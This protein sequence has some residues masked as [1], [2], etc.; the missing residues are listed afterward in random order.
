MDAKDREESGDEAALENELR[1]AMGPT[2]S[3]RPEFRASVRE[4]FFRTQL[5]EKS[6]SESSSLESA[7][8]RSASDSMLED[9][10]NNLPPMPD[11]DSEFRAELKAAFL[12]GKLEGAAT[13]EGA[14]REEFSRGTK[15]GPV[16]SPKSSRGSARNA[17]ARGGE[18]PLASG[19]ISWQV[20]TGILAIAAA[21][22]LLVLFPTADGPVKRERE[23]QRW[24]VAAK[25]TE[26]EIDRVK[27]RAAN[28]QSLAAAINKASSLASLD[29]SVELKL[30][31]RVRLGMEPASLLD[32][33]SVV[34]PEVEA[35]QLVSD[36]LTFKLNSGE[37]HLMTSQTNPD[38]AIV[39]ETPHAKVRIS[40]S[41]LS[42]E[43]FEDKG[44]CICVKYGEATVEVL[45]GSG[46]GVR[47]GSDATC[48]VFATGDEPATGPSSSL[49][50]PDHLAP[51][52]AFYDEKF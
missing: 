30:K 24:T 47:V 9:V 42:I 39:V 21:I 46:E 14:G 33:S 4:K 35:E 27:F 6:G 49:V 3:A 40:G 13:S 43:V 7:S 34:L 45:S 19:P 2:P 20:A 41:V 5:G 44:T 50:A 12:E 31:N 48:F 17:A 16:L 36:E 22:L 32:L 26:L 52:L 10:L 15:K 8:S 1:D 25:G 29:S 38:Q 23:R 37:L 11:A 18:S 28:E 51:L